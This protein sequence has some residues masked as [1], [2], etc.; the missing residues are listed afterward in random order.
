MFSIFP[1]LLS[2]LENQSSSATVPIL[3]DWQQPS[4]FGIPNFF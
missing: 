2:L 4:S 3:V 1:I